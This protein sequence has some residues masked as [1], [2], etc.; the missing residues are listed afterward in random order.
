V[1]LTY[2]HAHLWPIAP[3]VP[4]M[5]LIFLDTNGCRITARF[6]IVMSNGRCFLRKRAVTANG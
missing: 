4:T 2:N 5:R 1:Y 3:I 6:A